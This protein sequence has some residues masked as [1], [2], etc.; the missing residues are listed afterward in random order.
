MRDPLQS[1]SSFQKAVSALTGVFRKPRSFGHIVNSMTKQI[2]KITHALA[3]KRFVGVRI[4]LQGK[5]EWMPTLHTHVFTMP[6]SLSR[7]DVAVPADETGNRM[8]NASFIS[9][10]LKISTAAKAG[11]RFKSCA[12]KS[13]IVHRM[14]KQDTAEPYQYLGQL[15]SSRLYYKGFKPSRNGIDLRHLAL[16]EYRPGVHLLLQ[17]AAVRK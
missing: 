4:T 3:E 11:S 16:L 9:T 6:A 13:E 7:R 17:T 2:A 14:A 15:R 1:L 8:T 12:R 10:I 5:K